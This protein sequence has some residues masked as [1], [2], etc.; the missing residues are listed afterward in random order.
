MPE[1]KIYTTKLCPYCR[2]A[3]AFFAKHNIPFV[4][5][6]VE[7]N[8]QAAKEMVDLSGQFGIPVIVIGND[9]IVGFDIDKLNKLLGIREIGLEFDILIIGAGPAGLTAAM[10]CARKSLNTLII[11]EDIGGQALWSWSI[12]NYMGYRMITGEDLMKKFE[13]QARSQN[14]RVDL[15]EAAAVALEGDLFEVV[16]ASGVTYRGVCVILAQ[17]KR[18]RKLD[19]LGEDR[20]IGR[21]VSI[22][23]TC[24]GPLFWE[25]GCGDAQGSLFL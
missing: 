19:V 1:V 5:I 23:S 18:P 13:E 6:D 2:M 4:E 17:G 3:K 8:R 24:D 20:Y 7:G 25:K 10:Y 22:C 9:V 15:D 11:G 14:I 12:D 16:T 21:G